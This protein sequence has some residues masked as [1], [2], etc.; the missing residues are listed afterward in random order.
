MRKA[1]PLAAAVLITLALCLVFA[2]PE[3]KAAQPAP[4]DPAALRVAVVSDIHFT[5]EEGYRYVGS[6][7]AANDRSGT[8]KQVELLPALL[9]AFVGQMMRERP[10]L[11]LVTGDNA[12]N[13]AR[14]S[15]EALIGRLSELRNEGIVVLTLPGNHD[16]VS[17]ALVFPEGEPEPADSVSP[18]DFAALYADFGYADAFSRDPASLSYVYD[19]GRG[20]RVFMLDT[21]FRYGAP[22][23]HVKDGTLSWLREQLALCRAAGDR[24][25]VAG[26]HNLNV[27]NPLFRFEYVADNADELRA[28]LAEYGASLY[29]SGHLHPQ[30]IVEEGGVTDAAT[31]SFCVYPHRFGW[32]EIDGESW[33]YEARQTEVGRWAAESGCTDARLL[34]YESFGRDYLCQA[35][36]R[37]VEDAFGEIADGAL[38]DRVTA[39]LAEANARYFMGDPLPA[40]DAE[41]AAALETLPPGFRRSY[42]DSIMGIPASLYAEGRLHRPSE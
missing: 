33:R 24:A 16:I 10:D 39:A 2:L 26:H 4:K 28:L 35:G 30:T 37:S 14:L 6:F 17:S 32:I 19:S 34:H 3:R 7:A 20:L 29:L 11:L 5:G 18:E 23:G 1:L 9:D 21:V 22:Y 12:F 41:L 25:L 8:G 13:G 36:L 15:H 27:H 42:F 38:R 40:P 31:E